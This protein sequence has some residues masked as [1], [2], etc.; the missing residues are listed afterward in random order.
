MSILAIGCSVDRTVR[1]TLDVLEAH[2]LDVQFVDFAD[3]CLAGEVL[4][5]DTD[6]SLGQLALAG[7]NYA[8]R[9]Y[10]CFYL[11]LMD[12]ACGAPEAQSARRAKEVYRELLKVFSEIPRPIL[13]R[14]LGD[15][16]NMSKPFHVVH[17]GAGYRWRLPRSCLTS[18]PKDARD[19]IWECDA[20][21]IVKGVSNW[22]TWAS[23]IQLPQDLERLELVR[24]CPIF[25]QE[26]IVGPDV[27]VH[28]VA[29]DVFAEKIIFDG[30][31]YRSSRRGRH[32]SV[33]VPSEIRN[34]CL[35]LSRRSGLILSGIDFKISESNG[36]WYF[37]EIN[38]MPCYQGYDR[39]SNGAIGDAIGRWFRLRC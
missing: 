17:A 15:N 6:A 3:L 21:V 2:H 30:V 9:E 8:L 23:S 16:S 29:D 37:L 20:Q 32:E 5:S 39:R 28:V 13:N 26:R 22:K 27:R 35:E 38:A 19:F 14:P 33:T 1:H 25:L 11:R 34:D 36:A 31:D 4:R 7:N 10:S 24:E 18:N 12:L